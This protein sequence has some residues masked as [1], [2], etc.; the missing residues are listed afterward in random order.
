MSLYLGKCLAD[1]DG[2]IGV[3]FRGEEGLAVEK[4]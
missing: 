1:D 2:G 3:F 4:T